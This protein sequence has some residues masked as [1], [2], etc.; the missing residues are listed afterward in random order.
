MLRRQAYFYNRRF[1]TISLIGVVFAMSDAITTLI[2]FYTWQLIATLPLKSPYHM[3][4]RKNIKNLVRMK[5]FDWTILLIRSIFTICNIVT[6]HILNC[7]VRP[8][9]FINLR[10]FYLSYTFVLWFALKLIFVAF[11]ASV[12]FIT[13]IFA[14]L[15]A[16]TIFK[17]VYATFQRTFYRVLIGERGKSGKYELETRNWKL[18]S[19]KARI[20]IGNNEDLRVWAEFG[21]L[22][23]TVFFRNFNFRGMNWT[24][25]WKI[26]P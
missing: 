13:T 6:S 1:L 17:L 25:F 9:I 8:C 18:F 22:L 5:T 19:F 20:E 2:L 12:W 11:F 21:K 4:T 24:D 7:K 14:I 15:V 26:R 16:I 10:R 3:F 23:I